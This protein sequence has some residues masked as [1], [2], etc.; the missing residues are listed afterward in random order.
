M[1]TRD[2]PFTIS[3]TREIGREL[4]EL[5]TV[6]STN[7]HA[8]D[9]LSLSKVQHGAVILAHEQTEG[10]GQRGR[11]WSSAAGKDLTFSIVL[12]PQV[13]KASGQFM[14]AKLAALAVHDVVAGQLKW[15]VG[16]RDEE[17]RIKW[18]N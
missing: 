10:R 5:A 9:L 2:A 13:L 4:V 15:G 1:P 16:K 3:G 8:A 11:T 6:G 18:P 14:L 7:K 12:Q 17:V